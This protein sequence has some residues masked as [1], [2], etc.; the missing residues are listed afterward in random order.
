MIGL[1]ALQ[2]D[3]Y[4][5]GNLQ[6]RGYLRTDLEA[7]P[8]SYL[9]LVYEKM[10][11]DRF[12][13]HRPDGKGILETIFF[14][15]DTS[16]DSVVSFLSN[17]PVVVMGEWKGDLFEPAGI[18]FRT[19]SIAKGKGMM[20]GYV[21]FREYWGK[22]EAEVLAMMGIAFAFQEFGIQSLHGMRFST[23]NLTSN[24]LKRF[25]FKDT[26]HHPRWEMRNGELVGCTSS[27]LLIEDFE[28]YVEEQLIAASL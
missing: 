6:A 22:P 7:F 20:A 23:N 4:R 9:S 19:A 18:I 28:E 17:T 24:F 5:V 25:G 1:E 8:E 10:K 15:M 27:C 13:N 2:A 3:G 26:G 11:G 16:W 12:S 21:F 14:A